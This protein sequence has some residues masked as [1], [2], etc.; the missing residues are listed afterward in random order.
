M[1]EREISAGIGLVILFMVLFST[2]YILRLSVSLVTILGL[3][4]LYKS[5]GFYKNKVLSVLAC[6]MPTLVIFINILDRKYFLPVLY[7]YVL[8]LFVSLILKS[9]E[10][11]IKDVSLILS[12]TAVI[13]FFF[14]YVAIIRDM[15]NGSI[16]I[17]AVFIAGW[18]T[19]TFAFF[20]GMF[21][22]R[23]KLAPLVSPKK[24]IEGS[25]GGILG[26]TL[27]FLVYGYIVENF[28]GG[29]SANYLYLAILGVF[30][31]IIAQIGDLS[32]S[33]MKREYGIKDFGNIMP[34]HG[35][36]LDRFDSIIFVAPFVYYFITYFNI[37]Y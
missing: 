27:G 33:A 3:V 20:S 16:Y 26:S 7:V 36:I 17:W 14:F 21:F 37:F 22:G 1:K 5:F 30:G 19:D 8:I 29:M 10:I 25:I 31:S 9:K 6:I 2:N 32:A 4:E 15:E 12:L 11:S 18:L 28:I 13:T 24:T 34:G 23:H 35:G